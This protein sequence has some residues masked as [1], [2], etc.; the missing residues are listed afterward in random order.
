[1]KA[2]L[3]T[4]SCEIREAQTPFINIQSTIKMKET[5]MKKIGKGELGEECGLCLNK[6]GLWLHES[7]KYYCQPC[8]LELNKT[9]EGCCIKPMRLDILTYGDPV[10]R[11]AGSALTLAD[12]DGPAIPAIVA[13]MLSTMLDNHAL[14]LAAQQ[15]GFPLCITVLNVPADGFSNMLVNNIPANMEK[16]MPMVLINPVVELSGKDNLI[17]YPEGCLSFP[18]GTLEIKRS[19]AVKVK[20]L[21]LHGGPISFTAIG[22]LSVC[23]QHEVDHLNGKLF[24][25]KASDEQVKKMFIEI[26][27]RKHELKSPVQQPELAATQH[28]PQMRVS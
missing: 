6:P 21:D 12:L 15:V 17:T 22:L 18:G 8:A 3:R 25:D 28:M 10:L 24:I 19:S 5:T 2:K 4:L 27:R 14:G 9:S 20:A 26:E 1:M 7:G 23:I 13:G 11:T 16:F